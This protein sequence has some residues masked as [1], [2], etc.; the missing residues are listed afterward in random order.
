MVKIDLNN[1]KSNDFLEKIFKNAK[2]AIDFCIKMSN[3]NCIKF[4]K[5]ILNYPKMYINIGPVRD[6][7][8]RMLLNKY[9]R[10][11]EEIIL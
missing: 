5:K 6:T 2:K 11:S 8:I 9:K 1:E 3:E 7:N 10:Y 4:V